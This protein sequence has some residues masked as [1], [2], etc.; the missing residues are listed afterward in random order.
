MGILLQV[1]LI[2]GQLAAGSANTL[3]LEI[4]P[5]IERPKAWLSRALPASVPLDAG[6][7]AIW[8]RYLLGGCRV[9]SKISSQISRVPAGEKGSLETVGS[10]LADMVSIIGRAELRAVRVGGDQ[11]PTPNVDECVLR[12]PWYIFRFS[13]A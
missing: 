2:T 1:D 7:D 3:D 10:C 9:L 4:S 8:S 11:S 13:F 5:S 6:S 12:R